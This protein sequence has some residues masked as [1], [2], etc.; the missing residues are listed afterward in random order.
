MATMQK[1]NACLVVF[2]LQHAI[3]ANLLTLAQTACTVN[4]LC[5]ECFGYQ[6]TCP[7]IEL[8]LLR[9]TTAVRMQ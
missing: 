6:E 3:G 8:F 7:Y 5:I 2:L 9:G 4:L 1:D